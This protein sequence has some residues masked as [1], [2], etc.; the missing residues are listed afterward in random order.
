MIFDTGRLLIATHVVYVCLGDQLFTRDKQSLL[1]ETARKFLSRTKP[2]FEQ[3]PSSIWP[4]DTLSNRLAW[5][6]HRPLSLPQDELE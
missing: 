1:D 2:F 6:C 5:L 3:F 4:N